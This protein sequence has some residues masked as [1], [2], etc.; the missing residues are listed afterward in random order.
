MQKRKPMMPVSSPATTAMPQNQASAPMKARVSAFISWAVPALISCSS[1]RG[2]ASP[3][4]SPPSRPSTALPATA[5]AN[6]ATADH[7]DGR[8]SGF[9]TTIRAQ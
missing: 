6:Q 1:A 8:T 5:A 9:W 7:A 3:Q 2:A 4:I